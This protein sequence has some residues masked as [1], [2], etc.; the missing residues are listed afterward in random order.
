MYLPLYFLG[1]LG[2]RLVEDEEETQAQNKVAF[3]LLGALLVI[4]P[5]VFVLL[6]MLVDG[7]GWTRWGAVVSAF[8]V[9]ALGVYHDRMITGNYEA[10]SV[11]FLLLR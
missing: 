8:G 11:V 3:S 5:S 4:Y 6:W 1:R 7:M 9:W 10:L 2:A